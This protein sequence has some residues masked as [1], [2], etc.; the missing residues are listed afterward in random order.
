MKYILNKINL[1]FNRKKY[2]NYPQCDLIINQQEMSKRA[3]FNKT[4][5]FLKRN[6]VKLIRNNM[7]LLKLLID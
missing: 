1:Y 3:K 5:L 4:L 6:N 2:V 7:N